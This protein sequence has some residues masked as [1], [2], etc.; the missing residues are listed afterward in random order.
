MAVVREIYRRAG[1]PLTAEAEQGMRD[2]EQDNEQGKHGQ[3][4]YSLEEFGLS[5]QIVDQAFSE[6]IR[7]FK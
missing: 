2:W 3:H 5:G 1:H 7:R 6:Y 4:R